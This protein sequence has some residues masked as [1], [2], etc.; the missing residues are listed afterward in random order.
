MTV[1]AGEWW[2]AGD[3]TSQCSPLDHVVAGDCT[4]SAVEAAAAAGAAV[5]AAAAAVVVVSVGV[6]RPEEAPWNHPEVPGSWRLET[7]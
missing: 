6:E 3:Q 5:V 2:R 7:Y 4:C 1:M